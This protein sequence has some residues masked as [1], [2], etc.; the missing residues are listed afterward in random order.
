MRRIPVGQTLRDAYIFAGANLG[1][2]IG[3]IWVSMVMLTVAQFFTSFRFYNDFIEFMASGNSAHMGPAMLMM[4]SYLVALL[5][6]NA[7]MFTAVVQLALGARTATGF[8]HF[9]FGPLEWRMF[10]AFFA[11]AGLL[12]LLAITILIAANV[13]AVLVPHVPVTALAVLGIPVVFALVLARFLVLL[14]AI[15][16][17]ETTPTLRR[18]WALSAGNFLPLLGVLLGLFLPLLMVM[19][20]IER[21]VGE[22]ADFM[23]GSASQLQIT[24]AAINARQILPLMCG[25]NFLFSPLFIGLLAG[26]SVSAWRTLKDEPSVEILA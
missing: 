2:I 3:L 15:A 25:L 19:G 14:P 8:L 7:V 22:K 16:V 6:L 13:L 1:G 24:A 20:M 26:A 21:Q 17:S 10:R 23:L 12:L 4:I 11:L 9:A 5:L 18:A